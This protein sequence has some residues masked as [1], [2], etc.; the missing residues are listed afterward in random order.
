MC[1]RGTWR[2]HRSPRVLSAPEE[3]CVLNGGADD[4]VLTELCGLDSPLKPPAPAGRERLTDPEA[5]G[6]GLPRGAASFQGA[7]AL[8]A[9]RERNDGERGAG[10][11]AQ[12]HHGAL[13]EGRRCAGEGG[14]TG[15][16]AHC[17]PQ[18]SAWS[19]TT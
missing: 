16:E 6:K 3:R 4:A 12:L 13:R 10:A 1:A 11:R 9:K 2:D 5:T 8:V 14:V 7:G 15:L 18:P 17:A 19:R